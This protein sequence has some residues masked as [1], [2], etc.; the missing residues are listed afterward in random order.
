MQW[1]FIVG[2]S[3]HKLRL[4][5][6]MCDDAAG[7]ATIIPSPEPSGNV[8]FP[9]GARTRDKLR[10]V[11]KRDTS[12][13]RFAAL[14]LALEAV[15]LPQAIRRGGLDSY[16]LRNLA[17]VLGDQRECTPGFA[18]ISTC[19]S[20]Y[21]IPYLARTLVDALANNGGLKRYREMSSRL[22][23]EGKR[24]VMGC[25]DHQRCPWIKYT[26]CTCAPLCIPQ[27]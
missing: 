22:R 2:S 11:Q 9:I 26:P 24:L 4:E 23:K 16:D 12:L 1:P 7:L 14:E 20:K 8:I 5:L 10:D 25:R 13:V 21:G 15:K 27:Q 17:D 6:G 3:S 19:E 18:T